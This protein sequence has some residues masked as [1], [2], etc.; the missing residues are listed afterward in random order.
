[1]ATFESVG[2]IL[3]VAFLVGP[4]ATAYLLTD[5]LKVMLGLTVGIGIFAST[6]GYYLA[7]LL[8]G[9]IA[10]A[11][12]TVLGGVFLL[13]FLWSPVHGQFRRKTVRAV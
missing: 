10:G 1:V 12:A 11:I 9:S 13:A 2:A 8:D 3:V 6:A 7:V 4:P 5:N